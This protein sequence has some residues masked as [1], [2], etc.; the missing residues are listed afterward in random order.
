MNL[1]FI[2]LPYANEA[3]SSLI[4]RTALANGYNSC[5]VFLNHLFREFQ[6][7]NLLFKGGQF[8][9]V[10]SAAATPYGLELSNSFYEL[11]LQR[12]SQIRIIKLQTVH[13]PNQLLRYSE[14]AI[15]TEC[16]RDGWERTLKDVK[17]SSCC[18]FHIRWYLTR[19]PSC[20]RHLT[21]HNQIQPHCLC[22]AI[23]ES[24]P[25][26]PPDAYPEK[27]LVTLLGSGNQQ[28]MNLFSDTLLAL[29]FNPRKKSPN[30]NRHIFKAAIGLASNELEL[31]AHSL[32]FLSTDNS[33]LS[34][35]MLLAK[36]PPQTPPHIKEKVKSTL[37][38]KP[39]IIRQSS[40]DTLD[41][42][43]LRRLLD[44]NSYAWLKI[45]RHY[46]F[47]QQSRSRPNYNQTNIK[48][49]IAIQHEIDKQSRN[50]QAQ[51]LDDEIIPYT[52]CR[53][54]LHMPIQQFSQL[55]TQGV[56]G[57]VFQ[58]GKSTQSF[59]HR[60]IF[61]AFHN[62]YISI[63][64]LSTDFG[65][66]V[67]RL[68]RE[69]INSRVES[70]LTDR[71]HASIHPTP[72]FIKRVDVPLI[73][74]RVTQAKLSCLKIN[75]LLVVDFPLL[76]DELIDHVMTLKQASKC[77]E[78][79]IVLVRI[80]LRSGVL[81]SGYK[82]KHG[83]SYCVSTKAVNEC[84]SKYI[85]PPELS[86]L[87]NI[88]ISHIPSVLEQHGIC[89]LASYIFHHQTFY[90]YI[91]KDFSQE[92]LDKLNPAHSDYGR[93]RAHQKLLLSHIIR[94]QI[95]VSGADFHKLVDDI[96]KARPVHYRTAFHQRFLTY[97]E[98]RNIKSTIKNLVPINSLDLRYRT[99]IRDVV[100]RFIRP[101]AIFSIKIGNCIHIMKPD[102]TDLERFYKLNLT[103]KEATTLTGL[104][105]GYLQS[106]LNRGFLIPTK[107]PRGGTPIPAMCSKN[108]ITNAVY[109][110]TKNGSKLLL[111]KPM[112]IR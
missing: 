109:R 23:L 28:R 62:L 80:L 107:I 48:K 77:L 60:R 43:Q 81:A 76:P 59:L 11:E 94:R 3:P 54:M 104:P 51:P 110:Y 82:K 85:F 36:L 95:K 106:L 111:I 19:C 42:R 46:Q 55:C 79:S 39:T 71:G 93:A 31:C 5:A 64:Q 7:P 103:L 78:I 53:M 35:A 16:W 88:H 49:I 89:H 90:I 47:P 100:N 18:P 72:S 99:S 66:S 24:P 40:Q 83:H 4:R 29:N 73:E 63:W 32:D 75:Q 38:L 112:P 10:M 102:F 91:R 34:R 96:L 56:L 8:E 97:S 12:E 69:I 30:E 41:T 101:N 68:R 67:R 57:K 105:H 14:A 33:D 27:L 13:I 6:Y 86:A 22:G 70:L 37:N 21:W 2:P 17:T 45:R 20:K 9:S 61:D 65:L 26:E 50:Q 52:Q 98:V 44:I 74:S 108:S 1:P 92:L 87:L 25:A 58:T 15:C 84:R